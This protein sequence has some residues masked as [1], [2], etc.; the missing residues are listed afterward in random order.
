MHSG[1]FSK[2]PRRLP[3]TRVADRFTFQSPYDDPSA[4]GP[5][6][7]NTTSMDNA[8][9]N[10]KYRP[11]AKFGNKHHPSSKYKQNK[12]GNRKRPYRDILKLPAG[13]DVKYNK[14]GNTG[15]NVYRSNS[16]SSLR[17]NNDNTNNKLMSQSSSSTAY[18]KPI[19]L[20][21]RINVMKRKKNKTHRLKQ[22]G[23]GSWKMDSNRFHPSKVFLQPIDP[24]SP[25][26]GEYNIR[27]YYGIYL[28]T[29]LSIR[30]LLIYIYTHTLFIYVCIHT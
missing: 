26:P 3:V 28:S 18:I 6:T 1:G 10:N 17:R 20:K 14:L 2:G 13:L 4:N 22:K 11:S 27:K 30:S 23:Y 15:H 9:I 25:G 29:H 16:E 5:G 7:Y 21:S 8:T 19:T 12:A 24:S